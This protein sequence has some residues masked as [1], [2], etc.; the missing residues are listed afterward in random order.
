MRGSFSQ[1]TA[2]DYLVKK[3]R[4]PSFEVRGPQKPRCK[5]RGWVQSHAQYHQDAGLQAR[6]MPRVPASAV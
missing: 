1:A 5:G 2:S 4:S 6:G 3:A